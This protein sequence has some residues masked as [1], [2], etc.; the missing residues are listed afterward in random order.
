MGT[1]SWQ[2][3]H[4]VKFVRG[5]PHGHVLPA[6]TILFVEDIIRVDT[7]NEERLDR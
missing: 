1:T 7:Q 2:Q 3:E 5:S 6:M 4:F